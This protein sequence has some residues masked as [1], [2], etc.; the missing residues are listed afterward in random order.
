ML[1]NQGYHI[2]NTVLRLYIYK[3]NNSRYWYKTGTQDIT[4]QCRTIEMPAM[5]KWGGEEDQ[6]APRT[7]CS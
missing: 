3:L 5:Q 6:A 1:K 7:C 2:G 4:P